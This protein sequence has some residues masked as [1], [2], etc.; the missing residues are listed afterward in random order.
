[1]VSW[2]ISQTHRPIWAAAAARRMRSSL[3]CKARSASRRA[4]A[5]ANTSA[6]RCMPRTTGSGHSRSPRARLQ[7]TAPMTRPPTIKGI[8]MPDRIWRFVKSCRSASPS[9]G[10]SARRGIMKGWPLSSVRTINGAAVARDGNRGNASN[11]GRVYE[12][13]TMISRRS[14][15][16][17]PRVDRS[18]CNASTRRR[19]A[20]SIS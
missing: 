19:R 10:R 16:R 2:G 15:L 4:R 1:M 20:F 18:T 14:S 5:L 12:W 3:S 8:T 17:C 6:I 13:V 9:V 11:P 7:P